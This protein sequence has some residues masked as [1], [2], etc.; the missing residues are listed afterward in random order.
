MARDKHLHPLL[1]AHAL[2]ADPRSLKRTVRGLGL[3]DHY[4]LMRD[5]IAGRVVPRPNAK[6]AKSLSSPPSRL[7]GLSIALRCDH[8]L[9]AA[10]VQIHTARARVRGRGAVHTAANATGVR[11]GE[12]LTLPYPTR[13]S[14]PSALRALPA[15]DE[16]PDSARRGTI[17]S[18]A[19]CNGRGTGPDHR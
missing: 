6:Q 9:P 14:Y 8:R 4:K 7:L 17:S 10:P 16:L 3:H 12:K 1:A 11:V 13:Q 15:V 19:S 5:C 18:A 2:V